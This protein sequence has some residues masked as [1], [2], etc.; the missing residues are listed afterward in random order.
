ML[1]TQSKFDPYPLPRFEDT[2][3]T[4]FGSKYITVLDCYSGFSQINV[5]EEHKDEPH[6]LSSGHYEFNGLPFGLSNSPSNCQRLMDMVLKSLMGIECW[7]FLDD[8]VFRVC[9]GTCP[10][11]GKCATQTRR[12]QLTT[13]PGKCV[14]AQ[15][16]VQ[17][18]GFVLSEDGTSAFPDKLR[19]YGNILLRKI[20]RTL[21][22][23]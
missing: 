5:K 6:S 15:P 11:T 2:T 13:A 19:L 12:S 16:R 10:K 3:S 8:I 7:A 20:S 1:S 18:L 14:T 21:E 17:Y 22:Q 9:A 23:F 4:L